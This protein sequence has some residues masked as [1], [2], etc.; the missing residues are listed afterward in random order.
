MQWYPGKRVFD[1]AWDRARSWRNGMNRTGAAFALGCVWLAGCALVANL[2]HDYSTAD[3]AADA[4][5]TSPPADSL[6]GLDDLS[7]QDAPLLDAPSPR[8]APSSPDAGSLDANPRPDAPATPAVLLVA[9]DNSPYAVDVQTKLLATGAFSKIDIF[10]AQASTPTA[11][12]LS[13]YFSVLVWS[14]LCFADQTALG[15]ALATYY[16]GGGHV[17]LAYT[18]SVAASCQ[19]V[20]G[21][22]GTVANGYMLFATGTASGPAD[23]LGTIEVPG[24]PLVLGVMS[25]NATQALAGTGSPFNGTTVIASWTRGLPLIVAGTIH[26]RN[27]VDINMFPPSAD[28]QSN[29][30]TGN[31]AEIMRNALLYQ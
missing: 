19:E 3:A 16:D 2:S 24:S 25:L 15:D 6:A 5:D 31:G 30:W 27:R 13:G 7:T 12:Q 28:A 10:S 8:D 26:G 21:V 1:A 11:G 18:T 29:S 22:F 20:L 9:A 14:N 4:S 23:S 17:V